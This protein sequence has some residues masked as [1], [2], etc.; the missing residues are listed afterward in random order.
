MQRVKKIKTLIAVLAQYVVNKIA[1]VSAAVLE[2]FTQLIIMYSGTGQVFVVLNGFHHT[3]RP[4][5]R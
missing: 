2:G 3:S 1:L 4:R 5:S